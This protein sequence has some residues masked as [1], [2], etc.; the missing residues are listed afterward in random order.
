MTLS[1]TVIVNGVAASVYSEWFLDGLLDF[2]VT[3]TCSRL[4]TRYCPGQE[5]LR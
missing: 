1:G 4:L 2:L 3:L 5:G